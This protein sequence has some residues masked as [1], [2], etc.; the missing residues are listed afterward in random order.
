MTG[1]MALIRVIPSKINFTEKK[2]TIFIS[3]HTF[4]GLDFFFR[5]NPC[6]VE[7]FIYE[8][9]T[10]IFLNFGFLGDRD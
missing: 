8:I 1:S 6:C 10:Y 2:F 5:K 3:F 7:I 4:F 9:L